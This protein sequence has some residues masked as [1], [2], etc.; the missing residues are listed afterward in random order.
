[1]NILAIIGL[2]EGIAL[3]T[4]DLSAD[5]TQHQNI[6]PETA[7][8]AVKRATKKNLPNM[9]FHTFNT[10]IQGDVIDILFQQ[11]GDVYYLEFGVNQKL[12]LQK[13]KSVSQTMKIM[14]YVV[15]C[16][17][18]M[19]QQTDISEF[20]FIA[21]KEHEEK[22]DKLLPILSRKFGFKYVKGGVNHTWRGRKQANP[23]TASYT[24]EI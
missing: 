12:E 21:D 11:E 20:Y 24:I 13:D 4:N 2:I 17:H 7:M 8:G 19:A 16:I 23:A 10:K 1:M 6:P 9:P 22:Y 5:H 18:Y 14:S 15:S 3:S